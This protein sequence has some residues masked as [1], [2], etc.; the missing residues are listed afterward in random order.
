MNPGSA[1][2]YPRISAPFSNEL[3]KAGIFKTARNVNDSLPNSKRNAGDHDVKNEGSPGE[4]CLP[5]LK[6]RFT[7]D[8]STMM[9]FQLCRI[10][11]KM[12]LYYQPSL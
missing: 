12:I 5:L 8:K 10:L 11:H 2:S 4:C 7:T 3:S 9:D 6:R 1:I